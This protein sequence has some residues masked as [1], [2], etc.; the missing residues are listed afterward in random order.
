MQPLLPDLADLHEKLREIWD[1]RQ[2]SNNGN[3]A[4]RLERELAGF[5]DANELSVFPTGRWRS[6]LPVG[7]SGSPGK[8][9]R[10]PSPF[11]PR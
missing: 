5:L 3:M 9:S 7:C 4:V 2:L 8:S 6:R 10:R 11:R 1:S